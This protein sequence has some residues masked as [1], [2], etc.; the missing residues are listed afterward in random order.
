MEVSDYIVFVQLYFI[1]RANWRYHGDYVHV[2]ANARKNIL[3][4][5]AK[6]IF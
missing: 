1:D 6:D 3:S 5:T 4:K 2:Y